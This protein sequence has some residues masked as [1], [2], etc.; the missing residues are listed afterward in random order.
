CVPGH[1]V[2][3]GPAEGEVGGFQGRIRIS[4]GLSAATKRHL[5]GG[6]EKPMRMKLKILIGLGTA[7]AAVLALTPLA[8]GHAVVSTMQPQGKALPSARVAYVLR[9]PNEKAEQNT[10]EV[11]MLVPQ[12]VQTAISVKQSSD[13]VTKLVKVDTGQK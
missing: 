12:V 6:R 10:F 2:R 3:P 4:S 11:D 8:S 5:K 9:V 1:A 13:W 7:A